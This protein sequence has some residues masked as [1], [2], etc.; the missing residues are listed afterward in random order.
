MDSVITAF[1]PVFAAG[2]ASGAG[3]C[4]AFF[5][6]RSAKRLPALLLGFSGGVMLY[7]S[8]AELLP[9]SREYGEYHLSIDGLIAGMFLLALVLL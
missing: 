5:F 4:I 7:F 9:L 1:L 2:L 8:F 3:S 6:D